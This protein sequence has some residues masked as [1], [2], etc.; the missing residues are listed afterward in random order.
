M[1]YGNF[2]VVRHNGTVVCGKI[3]D[4]GIYLKHMGDANPIPVRE[5]EPLFEIEVHQPFPERFKVDDFRKFVISTLA[6]LECTP[7]PFVAGDEAMRK[8]FGGG[9]VR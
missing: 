1:R 8:M 4:R 2:V 9:D 7:E 5:V 3:G 6:Q